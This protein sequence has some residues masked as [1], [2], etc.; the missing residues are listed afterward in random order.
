MIE[1]SNPDK[2][3]EDDDD[4]FDDDEDDDAD[5]EDT[6]HSTDA[7]DTS[8]A[9][10]QRELRSDGEEE[11]FWYDTSP[12]DFELRPLTH[13]SDFDLHQTYGILEGSLKNVD[14]TSDRK[15]LT[16]VKRSGSIIKDEGFECI[17]LKDSQPNSPR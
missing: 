1:L 11:E 4:N 5:D 2:K 9:T 16:Y 8:G 15:N 7:K 10:I 17:P 13:L 6:N 3:K 14:E 12:T